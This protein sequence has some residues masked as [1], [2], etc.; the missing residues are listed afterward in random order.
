M[1]YLKFEPFN[2]PP[3]PPQQILPFGYDGAIHKRHIHFF[4]NFWPPS[5]LSTNVHFVN[6][7]KK[8]YTFD[9]IPPPQF[10]NSKIQFC[11]LF[12]KKYLHTNYHMLDCWYTSSIPKVEQ[13]F[14]SNFG[15][16]CLEKCVC[17]QFGIPP[18]Y[19]RSLLV[20]RPPLASV[21]LLWMTPILKSEYPTYGLNNAPFL[22]SKRY[23]REINPILHYIHTGPKIY[24]P[25]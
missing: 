2:L 14:V 9:R 21:L 20:N 1:L 25:Y 6:P 7:L 18:I 8:T 19:N 12:F 22:L 24:P 13:A 17:T 5:P 16:E 23:F 4:G 10:V 15:N 11:H 3:P